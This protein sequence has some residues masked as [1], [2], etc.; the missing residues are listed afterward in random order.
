MGEHLQYSAC[1]VRPQET[2]P[3]WP[4]V[5]QCPRGR[6]EGR[7]RPGSSPTSTCRCGGSICLSCCIPGTG[8]TGRARTHVPS[9]PPISQPHPAPPSSVLLPHQIL[10]TLRAHLTPLLRPLPSHSPPCSVIHPFLVHSTHTHVRPTIG[11]GKARMDKSLF[12]STR[13]QRVQVCECV[14]VPLGCAPVTYIQARGWGRG[15]KKVPEG[16]ASLSSGG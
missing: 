16:S 6:P 11:P 2:F 12:L 9:I 15:S 5:H 1:G 4:L 7:S 3:E 13:R 10:L 8:C 14:E